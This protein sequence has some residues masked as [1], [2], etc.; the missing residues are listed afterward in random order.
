MN[1][2]QKMK[3]NKIVL[4]MS[5]GVDS[6]TAALLLL[7]RG[8]DVYGMYFN[9]H[10]TGFGGREEARA[11]LR[12]AYKAYENSIMKCEHHFSEDKF[13]YKDA[14]HEFRD[15]VISDFC[16]EYKHGRT[17]NPCVICNP[18][19]KFR[20]LTETADALGAPYVATGHYAK[21]VYDEA[22][23][24]HFI[25]STASKK[26]Q[27]YMLYRLPQ[28]IISRLIFPLAE[29]AE[30]ESVRNIARKNGLSS[31]EKSDSQEICFID[32]SV[33]YVDFIKNFNGDSED[34]TGIEEGNFINAE[35]KVLGRHKGLVNYTIGQ[36][37]GLGIA[38]GYPAFITE[39]DC[40]NNTVT[41]GKN[42]T[43][44]KT[45]AII[46]DLFFTETGNA[47][48]P[49]GIE[50][51]NLSAKVRYAAPRAAVKIVSASDKKYEKVQSADSSSTVLKIIF[52]APQRA[53]T[54]GQSLVIYDDDGDKVIGGGRILKAL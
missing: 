32:N 31:A 19:I 37:K 38:L 25:A 2:E 13:I 4:G 45:E 40:E 11:A 51:R 22:R 28:E 43:L 47:E 7:E 6:T 26:D 29:F 18:D 8:Y 39:I 1:A 9:I 5:G 34:K 44:F 50:K 30:K 49:C 23:G 24:A 27:S 52:D 33:D 36:R 14:S 20:L 12:E 10:E 48:L 42:E 16:L 54:P 35:G 41:L 15:I 21:T 53:M 17:P 46:C 3:N